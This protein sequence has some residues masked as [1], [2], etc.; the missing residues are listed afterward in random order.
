MGQDYVAWHR[1]YDD[2]NSPLRWRLS[3]VQEHIGR[4]LDALS[5]PVSV[6][7]L[8]AGDGRDLLG[9]LSTR[10]DFASRVQATLVELHPELAEQARL[11]AEGL[12]VRV[13][14]ADAGD[15]AVYDGLIPADLVLMVGIFGNISDSDLEATIRAAPAFCRPGATLIWSRGRDPEIQ[16]RNDAVRSWFAESGFAEV[17]YEIEDAGDW[18]AMG[19]MR[20]QGGP[21][22]LEPGRRLFTFIR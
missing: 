2:P 18:P 20:Y 22:A 13:L 21:V 14:Q 9:V 11:A 15:P 17:A 16:D 6:V 7:S 10:P 12:D 8:C 4:T 1:K 3:R 19:V 5:G